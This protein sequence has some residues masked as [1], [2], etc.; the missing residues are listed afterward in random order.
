MD[1]KGN[2]YFPNILR[3]GGGRA[4]GVKAVSIEEV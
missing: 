1:G 3:I 2:T 4:T